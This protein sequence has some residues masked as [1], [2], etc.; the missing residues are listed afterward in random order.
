MLI[1]IFLL[2]TLSANAQNFSVSNKNW[3]SCKI[4]SDCDVFKGC[5]S[6]YPANKNFLKEVIEFDKKICPSIECNT[7]SDY[8]KRPSVKRPSAKC[9]NYKCVI[10]KDSL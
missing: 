8:V 10:A 1:I 2:N 5:C 3:Y 6:W 4:S 9:Q 7:A